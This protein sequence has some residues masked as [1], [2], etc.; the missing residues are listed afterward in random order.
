MLSFILSLSSTNNFSL[1]DG[2]NSFNRNDG[3]NCVLNCAGHIPHDILVNFNCL[4]F[5]QIGIPY[6]SVCK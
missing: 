6:V 2:G 5:T 4:C 3:I 1:E